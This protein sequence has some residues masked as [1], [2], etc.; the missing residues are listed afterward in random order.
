MVGRVGRKLI[1]PYSFLS[2]A[3]HL[4]MMGVYRIRELLLEDAN[5][6]LH[7]TLIPPGEKLTHRKMS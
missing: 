3:Q 1:H 2:D 6:G 4:I 7:Q 5:F